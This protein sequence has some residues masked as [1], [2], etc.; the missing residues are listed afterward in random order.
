MIVE[1]TYNIMV[2]QTYSRESFGRLGSAISPVT[3]LVLTVKIN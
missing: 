3:T 2:I 1:H